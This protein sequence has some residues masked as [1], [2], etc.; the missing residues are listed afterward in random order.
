MKKFVIEDDFWYLYPKVKIGVIVCYGIDNSIKHKDKYI[1]MIYNSEK[2]ALNH[3]K[4][5]EFSSNEVIK[6]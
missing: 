1:D 6:V 4:N 2:E 3:L 5:E